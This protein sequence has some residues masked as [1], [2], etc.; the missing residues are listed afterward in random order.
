MIRKRNKARRITAK[1]RM[2]LVIL[3]LRSFA[4]DSY[5]HYYLYWSI[6]SLRNN[7]VINKLNGYSVAT[8]F[9]LL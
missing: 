9:H 2:V 3:L 8:N 6:I 1:I 7:L 4:L 5:Y